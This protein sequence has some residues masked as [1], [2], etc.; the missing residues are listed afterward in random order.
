[1]AK[2]KIKLIHP[3]G[4]NAP[5]LQGFGEHNQDYSR[6]GLIGHS[7]IDYLCENKPVYASADG[8]PTKIQVEQDGFGLHI[9]LTHA[10][11]DRT[12]Y[13]HL[14]SVAIEL[15]QKV[16]QGDF[17]GISGN[18]GFSTVPH[19]HFEYRP[20]TEPTNNGYNGAV[21]PTPFMVELPQPNPD[22]N[23]QPEPQPQPEPAEIP[24]KGMFT[25]IV[26]PILRARGTPNADTGVIYGELATN[27]SLPYNGIERKQDGQIWLHVLEAFWVAAYYP[28]G[29]GGMEWYVRIGNAL[30]QLQDLRSHGYG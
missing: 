21:D 2:S 25:V 1:M 14:S 24:E 4:Y 9:R 26:S 6:F 17:I 22:P 3:L 20:G 30:P 10:G 12:I 16:K 5:I 13:A 27:S 29:S 15:N 18:S 8:V 19:L 28:D 7:G 23:P 11:G